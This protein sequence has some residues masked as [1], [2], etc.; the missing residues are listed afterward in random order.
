MFLQAPPVGYV[1][2]LADF[3][4]LRLLGS[5]S[6]GS[7]VLA[8]DRHTGGKVALKVMEKCRLD[9]EKKI[10]HAINERNSLQQLACPFTVR[11]T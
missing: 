1:P 11:L 5:G 2:S 4:M 6:F 8:E 10:E 7:V 3:R 9:T